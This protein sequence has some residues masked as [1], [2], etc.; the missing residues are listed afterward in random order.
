MPAVEVAP[1]SE[2]SVEPSVIEK[3]D[4]SADFPAQLNLLQNAHDSNDRRL[5]SRVLHFLPKVRKSLDAGTIA[6]L[7]CFSK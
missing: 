1:I 6:N 4:L 5:V 2:V 7:E 3:V